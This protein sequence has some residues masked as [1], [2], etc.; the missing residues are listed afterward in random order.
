MFRAVRLHRDALARIEIEGERPI[1]IG[2][3]NFAAERLI[4][5]HYFGFGMAERVAI[6]DGENHRL[7]L[8]LVEENFS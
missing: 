7:R 6:A 4:A 2:T 1:Q 8:D 3:V 5:L